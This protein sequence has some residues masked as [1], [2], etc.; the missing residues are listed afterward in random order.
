M[1]DAATATTYAG[2]A[3]ALLGSTPAAVISLDLDQRV[4]VW[5]PSAERLL[6][7]GAQ[8][9]HGRPAAELF[10]I[11][12]PGS[13]Q[14]I[15][16]AVV[17]GGAVHADYWIERRDG[18]RV[19]VELRAAS[20]TDDD[21]N[22][23]AVVAEINDVTDRRRRE[24]HTTT[25]LE[26]L[27]WQD[28]LT[29]LPNRQALQRHLRELADGPQ[30]GP[31]A[32]VLLDLDDFSLINDTHGHDSGDV[33]LATVAE[34]L[35]TV[36]APQ[37]YVARFGG[38]EF[39]VVLRDV[40]HAQAAAE[41]LLTAISE[42]FFLDGQSLHATASAGLVLCPPTPVSEALRRADSSMYEA[43]QAGRATLHMYDAS[44]A[45][46]AA[47]LLHL[48]GALRTALRE[49]SNELATHYQPIFE[50]ATDRLVALEALARWHHPQLGA[51]PAGRFCDVAEHT[52]LAAELDLR[53][54]RR[55]L[56][57]YVG[58]LADHV[59]RADTRISVNIAAA[60]LERLGAAEVI[61]QAAYD[62]GVTPGQII[63]EVT[64]NAVLQ[65]VDIARRALTVLRA[66]GM[67]VVVDDFG[68]GSSSLA[69]VRAL[70]IDA[71][72]IDRAFVRN[73]TEDGEDFA[74]VAALIDLAHALGLTVIAEGVETPA[75]RHLL[76]QLKCEQGQG[77]LWSPPVAKNDLDDVL[78]DVARRGLAAATL[79]R[80]RP[81]SSDD[82][83]VAGREH[84]LMRMLELH[85][86]G[87]S[88]T[89]IAAALNA[90]GFRSPEGLRWHR[91]TVAKSLST[92]TK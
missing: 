65:D 68:T 45:E 76:A 63:L 79:A 8:E 20:V 1:H 66:Q 84:G 72:K 32:V 36:L 14:P 12:Q 15:V 48:S 90:E 30:R 62:A 10:A 4:R 41:R 80:L 13:L 40:G 78:R 42:P 2:D 25:E 9:A 64:E 67:F 43:K 24:R 81:R 57:D 83:S 60:H 77:F 69:H 28:A 11:D 74:I 71:I 18:S 52:G 51:I 59:I 87:K 92:L 85:R 37:D 75:Q 35:R 21:G 49:D 91:T 27:A 7:W 61:L 44:V 22:I 54:M 58:L 82:P 5:N 47:T 88:A 55:A 23:V 33:V 6:L 46:R 29:R 31:V 38:D 16:D 26:R 34:R 70:P 73:L 3:A 89:T 50:F 86:D 19:E 39:V 53:T 17:L 56:D